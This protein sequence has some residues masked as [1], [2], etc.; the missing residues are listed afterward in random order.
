MASD[1]E[2]DLMTVN[3]KLVGSNQG[4][5]NLPL[6][7]AHDRLQSIKNGGGENIHTLMEYIW[8]EYQSFYHEMFLWE[9]HGTESEEDFVKIYFV[10]IL[11][12]YSSM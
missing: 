9:T 11:L 5:I 3:F 8:P 4:N 7:K 10:F 2:D 12:F 6:E 1:F